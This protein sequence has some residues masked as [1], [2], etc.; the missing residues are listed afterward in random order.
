MMRFRPNAALLS[1]LFSCVASLA[2]AQAV[3]QS[4]GAVGGRLPMYVPS[5]STISGAPGYLTD[6]GPAGAWKL[7]QGVTEFLQVNRFAGSGPLNAHSCMYDNADPTQTGH[8]LCFDANASGGG[9]IEYG[10]TNGAATLPLNCYVNGAL[11][12]CFGTQNTGPFLSNGAALNYAATPIYGGNLNSAQLMG[13]LGNNTTPDTTVNANLIVQKTTT[14]AVAGTSPNSGAYFSAVKTGMASGN[15]A[16]G[17]VAEGYD[18]N[19]GNGT[20]VEG[21]RLHGTV[22]GASGAGYGVICLAQNLV[23]I[24]W[25]YLVGCESDIEQNAADVAYPPNVNHLA[26]GFLATNGQSAN[27]NAHTADAAFMANPFSAKK[28]NVGFDVEEGSVSQAA[29]RSAATTAVGLDLSTAHNTFAGIELANNTTIRY[30]G[31]SNADLNVMY[32]PSGSNAL[33]L[34]TDTQG[35]TIPAT[36]VPSPGAGFISAY[37]NGSNGQLEVKNATGTVFAAAP[38]PVNVA[39][40]PTCNST[41]KGAT[42]VAADVTGTP[43]Y[44][45][46]A[47]GGGTNVLPVFCNGTNWTQH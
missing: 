9:L 31:V 21:G 38:I 27:L 47:T 32:V 13:V 41:M 24:A 14:G 8:Y 36:S 39:S 25:D 22:A 7:G 15:R 37:M 12:P 5:S 17:L 30:K 1:I 34:G 20:F 18:P 45:A 42:W 16:T 2:Y 28:W 10:A 26:V 40:L 6:S 46:V 3:L 43:T 11:Q 19:G 44:N 29:F 4:G 33:I 23:G 35:I